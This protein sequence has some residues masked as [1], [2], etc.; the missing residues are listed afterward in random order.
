MA[1]ES[2]QQQQKLSKSGKIKTGPYARG[3]MLI[4]DAVYTCLDV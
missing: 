2:R 4:M 1:L 3:K